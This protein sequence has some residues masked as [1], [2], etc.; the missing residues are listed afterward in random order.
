MD[1]RTK[2][3]LKFIGGGLLGAIAIY[4]FI[5]GERFKRGTV[6]PEM[7]IAVATPSA[8]SLAGFIEFVSGIPFG[9][10]ASSWDSLRGWQRGVIGLLVVAAAFAVLIFGMVLFA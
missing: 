3:L 10:L 4:V 8:Y 9:K 5:H 1:T 2:G 6:G 7:L